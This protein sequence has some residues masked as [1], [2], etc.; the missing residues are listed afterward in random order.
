LMRSL[1]LLVEAGRFCPLA[2]VSLLRGVS[3]LSTARD[4]TCFFEPVK[5]P[6]PALFEGNVEPTQGQVA[7][8]RGADRL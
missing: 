6:Q 2:M 1:G 7:P 3:P 5:P 8:T 4:D